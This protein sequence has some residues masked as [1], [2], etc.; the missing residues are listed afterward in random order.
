MRPTTRV[1]FLAVSLAAALFIA[2]VAL[3]RDG[4]VTPAAA[5]ALKDA[6]AQAGVPY[7]PPSPRVVIQ[8]RDRRLSLYSGRKLLKEY[9]VALGRAPLGDK[10]QQGDGRTPV[11]EFYVCTRLRTSRFHRFMGL[12]YPAPTHA[13]RGLAEGRIPR[14]EYDRILA[15]HR[16]R[17][18]PP[19]GTPLGGAIGIHGGGSGS[20]W[21]L[22][23]IALDNEAIEELF[24]VLPIGVPVQVVE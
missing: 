22:G 18:Q 2:W 16:A 9:P 10:E 15:S 19:W 21:T 11:G 7:P 20:D 4:R 1:T 17:R 6:S 23:C 13:Q 3:T 8:K 12:S 24:A 14:A 5:R